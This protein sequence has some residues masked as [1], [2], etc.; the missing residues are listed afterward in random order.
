MGAHQGGARSR[1]SSERKV[2]LLPSGRIMVGAMRLH[3]RFAMGLLPGASIEEH[4]QL[5]LVPQGCH[6]IDDVTKDIAKQWGI[7]HDLVAAIAG[8]RVRGSA[9]GAILRDNDV[10]ELMSTT[11]AEPRRPGERL[12]SDCGCGDYS[13]FS[14]WHKKKLD[15]KQPALCRT[16]V[17]KANLCTSTVP[18]KQ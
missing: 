6:S 13:Q 14:D 11:T 2:R 3:L 17:A 1:T 10:M 16:C 18:A 9:P 7:R 15:K 12:C 8:S 5:Y 4:R